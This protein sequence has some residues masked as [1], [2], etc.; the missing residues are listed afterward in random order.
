MA[1]IKHRGYVFLIKYFFL[2]QRMF[3]EFLRLFLL[4][5]KLLPIL[6]RINIST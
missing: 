5:N 2:C 3:I 1:D 6:C 4:F